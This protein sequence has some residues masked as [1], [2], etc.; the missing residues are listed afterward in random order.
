M[1]H[2]RVIKNFDNHV[3]SQNSINYKTLTTSGN[4]TILTLGK[5]IDNRINIVQQSM[6]PQSNRSKRRKTAMMV[7][8]EFEVKENVNNEKGK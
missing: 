8:E 7:K 6:H 4:A 1:G 2:Q 3:Q 5:K